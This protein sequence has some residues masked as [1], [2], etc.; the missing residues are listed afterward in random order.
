MGYC[1]QDLI[2]STTVTVPTSATD[3]TGTLFVA[4]WE[5]VGVSIY[6]PGPAVLV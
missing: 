1:N 6:N 5:Q 4:D 3:V 2:L